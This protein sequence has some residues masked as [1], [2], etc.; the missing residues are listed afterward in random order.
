M[1]VIM[2]KNNIIQFD[3]NNYIEQQSINPYFENYKTL[4]FLS[5]L[6][7]GKKAQESGAALENVVFNVLNHFKF[8]HESVYDITISDQPTYEDLYDNLSKLDFKINIVE[9]KTGKIIEI[10][11][12]V[13]QL[14]GVQSH[15]QKLEWFFKHA[16]RDHLGKY[17]IMIYDYNKKIKS[18]CKKIN[19]LNFRIKDVKKT[20]KINNINI[21]VIYL[22]NVFN[23]FLNKNHIDNLFLKTA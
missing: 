18:A 16:E 3:L 7:A 17:P 14:G 10:L 22:H 2:N 19:S 20:C 1:R 5:D 13:K 9:K 4:S 8:V 23:N 21:D 15:F 6:C 12:E 11:I